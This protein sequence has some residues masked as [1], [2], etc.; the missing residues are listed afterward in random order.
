MGG[1]MMITYQ[2]GLKQTNEL[3]AIKKN[4]KWNVNVV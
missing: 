2:L 1:G 3:E 4:G